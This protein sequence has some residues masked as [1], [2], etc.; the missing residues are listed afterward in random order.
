MNKTDKT[1]MGTVLIL[2]SV[3]TF[4]AFNGT[5]GL[6]IR[7]TVD[8]LNSRSQP[9]IS[10]TLD[11]LALVAYHVGQATPWYARVSVMVT[12]VLAIV[13]T[14]VIVAALLKRKNS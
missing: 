14:S 9:A 8:V 2:I 1:I 4:V 11:E 6:Y 13:G 10:V 7:K 3:V 12:Y 5:N